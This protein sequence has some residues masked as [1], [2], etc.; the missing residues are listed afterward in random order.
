MVGVAKKSK[1][2]ISIGGRKYALRRPTPAGTAEA[3]VIGIGE[4]A[5]QDG[6]DRPLLVPLVTDGEVIGREPLV[7]ARHR[8]ARRPR[9]A[10]RSA[11][12]LQ[13]GEPVIPTRRCSIL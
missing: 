4:P 12:Q 11:R 6:D 7:A 1:D 3:E 5:D 10:P 9:R 13:H 2:K 8:H